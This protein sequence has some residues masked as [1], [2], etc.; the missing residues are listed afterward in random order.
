[1]RLN[2][3]GAPRAEWYD[4]NPTS[5]GQT[6][7]TTLSENTTET[8]R[9]TYTTPTNRLTFV[10]SVTTVLIGAVVATSVTTTDTVISKIEKTPSGGAAKPVCWSELNSAAYAA[11]DRD[12]RSVGVNTILEAG[13][14]LLGSDLFVGDA[15]GAGRIT[16]RQFAE[17]VEFDV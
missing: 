12:T 5:T 7:S 1:M 9:W 3:A 10:G 16:S 8:I 17:L 2:S 15:V 13:D 11:G 14:K 4:R 6:A